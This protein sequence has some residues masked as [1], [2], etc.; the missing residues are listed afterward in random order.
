MSTMSNDKESHRFVEEDAERGA[1]TVPDPI[2]AEKEIYHDDGAI[3]VD[4]SGTH[5]GDQAAALKTA[6]DGH[7]GQPSDA[8]CCSGDLW[9][10]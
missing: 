3:L 8:P 4:L 5:K 7:V 2:Q 1:S 10:R 9:H 6:K